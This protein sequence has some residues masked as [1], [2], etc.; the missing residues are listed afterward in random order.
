MA[1]RSARSEMTSSSEAA[2]EDELPMT[3]SVRGFAESIVVKASVTSPTGSMACRS[4]TSS[5]S[6]G[7][8]T[9]AMSR[10]TVPVRTAMAMAPTALR[11]SFWISRGTGAASDSASTRLA[12]SAMVSRSESQAMRKLAIEGT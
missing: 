3:R 8:S 6:G 9:V 12:A 11:R 5:T 1:V 7:I 10:L 4:T 2:P